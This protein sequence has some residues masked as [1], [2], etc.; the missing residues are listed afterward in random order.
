MK[1]ILFSVDIQKCF[2]WAPKLYKYFIKNNEYINSYN[3][4]N[5]IYDVSNTLH[6]TF[7]WNKYNFIEKDN[8]DYLNKI[9]NIFPKK[10]WYIRSFYDNINGSDEL[11]SSIMKFLFNNNIFWELNN[12]I[13]KNIMEYIN[14]NYNIDK[15]LYNKIKK[16]LKN[17]YI[18][19]EIWEYL[20][21][22]IDYNDEITLIWW[23]VDF[24]LKEFYFLLKYIGYENI[25]ID[26]N[27]T[28]WKKN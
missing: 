21:K 3:E 24:C 17:T 7:W 15:T 12:D 27:Y 6:Y 16:E 25:N 4:Y 26:Y 18:P 19:K 28:Y 1:K 13:N 14:E 11:L 2:W 20:Y 22:N 23:H 8:Y 5:Y 10:F 9:N